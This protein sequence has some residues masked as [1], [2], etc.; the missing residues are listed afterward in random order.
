MLHMD[1]LIN[2]FQEDFCRFLARNKTPAETLQTKQ[3]E[4]ADFYH[5]NSRKKHTKKVT[6]VYINEHH[7]V[8]P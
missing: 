3:R 7:C 2:I 6:L 4:T 8:C 1:T 5:L